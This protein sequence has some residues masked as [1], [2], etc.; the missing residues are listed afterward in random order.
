MLKLTPTTYQVEE[1]S[2]VIEQIKPE[3]FVV[4]EDSK[5]LNDFNEWT[6]SPTPFS[7]DSAKKVVEEYFEGLS[8]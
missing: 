3:V 6:E 2:I 4:R 1:S 5:Y 8:G 7:L